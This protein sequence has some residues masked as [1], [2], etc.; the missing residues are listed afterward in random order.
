VFAEFV[1]AEADGDDGSWTLLS[2][3]TLTEKNHGGVYNTDVE[4]GR[5]RKRYSCFA[6]DSE[7][8]HPNNGFV[9]GHL[10]ASLS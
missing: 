10:H 3:K 9:A 5:K 6:C 1:K 2:C 7:I 8:K 4:A